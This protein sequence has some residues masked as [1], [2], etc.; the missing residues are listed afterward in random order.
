MADDV[1]IGGGL[2]KSRSSIIKTDGGYIVEISYANGARLFVLE[3]K[4]ISLS[5]EITQFVAEANKAC[6]SHVDGYTYFP[7]ADN[8]LINAIRDNKVYG[9]VDTLPCGHGYAVS[10]LQRCFRNYIDVSIPII[11]FK[12]CDSTFCRYETDCDPL[13]I[14]H[15]EVVSIKPTN[16]FNLYAYHRK[17]SAI[18]IG[19]YTK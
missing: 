13:K 4:P 9:I 16:D 1:I 17:N 2:F 7:I 19:D 18:N 3:I 15:R 12:T 14:S 5:Q 8:Q 11:F 6:L 10:F